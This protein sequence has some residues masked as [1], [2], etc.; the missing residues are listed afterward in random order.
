MAAYLLAWGGFHAYNAND[1]LVR[2]TRGAGE[3][4]LGYVAVGLAAIVAGILFAALYWPIESGLVRRK[5]PNR[6]WAARLV[7][8]FL[9]FLLIW[10][11]FPIKEA[12]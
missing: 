12:L 11:A 8:G 5:F 6:V 9:F 1:A 7:A 4:G 10:L 2:I 3:R